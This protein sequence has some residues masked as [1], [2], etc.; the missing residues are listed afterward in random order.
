M[1]TAP[2][3][4]LDRWIPMAEAA[5]MAGEPPRRFRRRMHALNRQAGGKLLRHFGHGQQKR[6]L[7]VSAEALMSYMRTDPDALDAELS[8]LT[9][10]IEELEA[11]LERER[12]ARLA[13]QAQARRWFRKATRDHERP[14]FA[15]GSG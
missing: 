14:R 8:D 11:A 12:K 9:I 13:F 2:T 6:R 15:R 4:K 7:H 3:L 5:R 10:R 1:S